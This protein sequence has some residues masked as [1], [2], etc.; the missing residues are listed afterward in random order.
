M[1]V[2]VQRARGAPLELVT[3]TDAFYRGGCLDGRGGALS[4]RP[5]NLPER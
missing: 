4:I 2:Q 3:G 1:R 5:W